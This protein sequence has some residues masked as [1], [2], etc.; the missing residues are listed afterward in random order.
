ML[1]VIRMARSPASTA[2]S[3]SSTIVRPSSVSFPN[4]KAYF[5]TRLQDLLVGLAEPTTREATARA[6]ARLLGAD[7]LIVFI[8]DPAVGTLL[9]AR[10]SPDAPG[11]P[12]GGRSSAPA[13]PLGRP[14]PSSP[15][16]GED[17]RSCARNRFRGPI[18]TRARRR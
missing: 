13:S 12:P 1:V 14:R 10:D 18:G 6:L 7:D 4:D 3:A 11:G 15:S 16:G 17:A 5:G 9:P 2:S 8:Q